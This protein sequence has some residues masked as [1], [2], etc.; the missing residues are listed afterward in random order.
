VLANPEVKDVL[1]KQGIDPAGG[2]TEAFDKLFRNEVVDAREG[3]QSVGR[4]A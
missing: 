1:L 3:D 4:Q 2:T